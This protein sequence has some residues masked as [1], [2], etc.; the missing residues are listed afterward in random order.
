M[1]RRKVLMVTYHFP[2]SAAVAV[3]RMLGCARH[4][5]KFGWDMCVVAPPRMPD[6][7]VD[8]A[9]ARQIPTETKIYPTPYPQHWWARQCRRFVGDGI[10]LPRALSACAA[11]IERERPDAL[12]TSSPPG[13]IHCIG[14][15]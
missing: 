12:M 11:A 15:L 4:L 10:W 14:L 6:E 2:P 8:E 9:L 13:A 3:Y 1:K 5:P 7:P